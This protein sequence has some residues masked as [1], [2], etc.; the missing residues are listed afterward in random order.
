VNLT[1][2]PTLERVRRLESAGYIEA[3]RRLIPKLWARPAA[4]VEVSLDRTT[5]DASTASKR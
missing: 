4:Y 1:V 3:I 2:T 5:P